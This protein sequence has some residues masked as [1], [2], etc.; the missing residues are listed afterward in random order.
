MPQDLTERGARNSRTDL[1]QIQAIHDTASD[2]GAACSMSESTSGAVASDAQGKASALL[3]ALSNLRDELA[4]LDLRISRTVASESSRSGRKRL[5]S[6]GRELSGHIHTT[7]ALIDELLV[8]GQ[9]GILDMS[10]SDEVQESNSQDRDRQS[11]APS[12]SIAL[13]ESAAT[14]ENIVLKE[15]KADYE[16]KLIAPGPGS[17]AFYP[18]EVL[19]RDGP[20]VFTAGTHVYLNH[21][22]SAEEAARPEGDVR[23]LAGV[24]ST[25]ATYS[26]S[27][28]KGPGLYA[29]MKVF[30]DHAQTVEEKAPHVGMS[31]R[32]SGVA[33]S[34]KKQNGLP[35]LKEL[36]SAE[37]VDVVTRAGA[38]GMILTE[39][40]RPNSQEVDMT[41]EEIK[42]LVESATKAAVTEAL[43]AVA[44]P[45]SLLETRALRGD[46]VV[47]ANKIL[48][49]L[50]LHEAFKAEVVA[51]SLRDI[52]I[53]EGAL[54]IPAFTALVTTE[55]KRLGSLSATL[56]RSG[57]VVDMGVPI[58]EAPKDQKPEDIMAGSVKTFMRLGLS[59]AAAK[60]AVQGRAA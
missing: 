52:P 12:Q 14:L 47:E 31:I 51:N 13:T 24:L 21:P 55:A 3:E 60:A 58:Q 10:A 33:E 18:K 48:A 56:T 4:T 37:S 16:I 1:A 49:P 50:T 39:A 28:P 45:V 32:A 35:V 27:H 34:N 38:G 40:A 26:E 30:A 29:R 59:E 20:K 15:S 19:Q 23:N 2:L 22:T 54:D 9:L 25:G 57:Q 7:S 41:T 11:S 36:T 5:G 43:A 8:S 44:K 42:A 46:A 17:S 6:L 53:K